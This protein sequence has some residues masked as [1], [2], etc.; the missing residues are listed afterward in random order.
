M[1][2]WNP[3]SSPNPLVD[4]L[5]YKLLSLSNPY[6]DNRFP[7]SLFIQVSSISLFHS[8]FWYI[9]KINPNNFVYPVCT[10]LPYLNQ[11][12]KC[13][14]WFLWWTT[15][16]KIIFVHFFIFIF[17]LCYVINIFLL[18]ICILINKSDH[19]LNSWWQFFSIAIITLNNFFF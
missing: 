1:P 15:I 2:V 16:I 8:Q 4:Y 7:F 19:F 14:H 3:L 10:P 11:I 5:Y 9:I 18:T 6:L 13:F 12:F 17:L